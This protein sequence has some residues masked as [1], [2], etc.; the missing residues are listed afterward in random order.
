V[1]DGL[2]FQDSVS[3]IGQGR[4]ADR[5]AEHLD[6]PT[7]ASSSGVPPGTASCTLWLKAGR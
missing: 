2:K 3:Q 6:G 5:A 4:I 1:T 7:D